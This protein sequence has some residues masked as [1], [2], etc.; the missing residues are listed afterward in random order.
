MSRPIQLLSVGRVGA[1]FYSANIGVPLDRVSSFNFYVGGT[2]ANVAVGAQRLGVD[3]ALVSRVGSDGVGDGI[4]RFLEEEGI[5]TTAVVRDPERRSG[6]VVLGVE[7]PDHF[8]LVFYRDRPADENLAPDDLAGLDLSAV[9]VV[10]VAGT[11]LLRRSVHATTL[12]ALDIAKSSDAVVVLDLDYRP[13]LWSSAREYAVLVGSIVD[14][15]DVVIGTED[16][17]AAAGGE[18]SVVGRFTTS[19]QVLVCKRGARGSDVI[20][21]AVRT[22][23]PPFP[24]EVLNVFGAGDAFA[25]GYIAGICRGLMPDECARLGNAAG[26]HVVTRHACANDMPS[27]AELRQILESCPPG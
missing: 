6:L 11:N 15:A 12:A 1:D 18:D 20:S 27:E 5:D 13:A 14:R 21:E 7:P 17:I 8:P 24:V 4:V 16:E 25:A 23:I 22:Q 10:F 26:A 2:P 3:T 9:E 19:S